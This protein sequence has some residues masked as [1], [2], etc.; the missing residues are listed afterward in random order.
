MSS[1]FPKENTKPQIKEKPTAP[2]N[3][4][5]R[6]WYKIAMTIFVP[7]FQTTANDDQ[8]LLEKQQLRLVVS[9]R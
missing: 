7:P 8:P 6:N 2:S 3:K 1:E 5:P 4:T 9:S